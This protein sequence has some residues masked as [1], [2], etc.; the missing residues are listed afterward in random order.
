MLEAGKR[1]EERENKERKGWK[2]L[3]IKEDH[4]ENQFKEFTYMAVSLVS[5]R[6]RS[7]LG[8]II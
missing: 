6:I 2:A 3:L 1:K 8:H 5:N 4:I 7:E